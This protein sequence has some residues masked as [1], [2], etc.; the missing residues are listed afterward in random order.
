MIDA[1]LLDSGVWVASMS[2]DDQFEPAA[3]ELVADLHRRFCALDLTLYEVA[4]LRTATR[5]Q[6][7]RL[8]RRSAVRLA[9]S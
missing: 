4:D 9:R 5:G 6:P 8:L 1:L 2:S 3:R 7:S